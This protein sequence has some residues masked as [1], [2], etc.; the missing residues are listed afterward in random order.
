MGQGR[1]DASSVLFTCALVR[2]CLSLSPSKCALSSLSFRF[3]NL[4]FSHTS[5]RTFLGFGPF[6]A[7]GSSLSL[8]SDDMKSTAFGEER[9]SLA[10]SLSLSDKMAL[11]KLERRLDSF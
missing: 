1:E 11:S 7:A 5:L 4:L 9:I 3:L 10:F 2:R 8:S 6:V